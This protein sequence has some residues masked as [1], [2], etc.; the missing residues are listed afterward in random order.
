MAFKGLAFIQD[1]RRIVF[2]Y[3]RSAEIVTNILITADDKSLP[4]DQYKMKQFTL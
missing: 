4:A 2:Y 3:A 1:R